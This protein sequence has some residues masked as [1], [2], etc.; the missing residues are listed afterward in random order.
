MVLVLTL[1]TSKR[2]DPGVHPSLEQD[3]T[4]RWIQ[5]RTGIQEGL[6]WVSSMERKCPIAHILIM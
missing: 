5:F 4:Q 3:P 2:M 6:E 1:P